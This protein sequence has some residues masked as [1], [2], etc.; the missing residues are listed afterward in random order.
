MRSHMHLEIVSSV[1]IEV[2]LFA[3]V[4][5]FLCMVSYCMNFQ[6]TSVSARILTHCAPVRL[7]PRVGP[8]VLLQ[9]A[10]NNC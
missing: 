6:I 8:Y 9:I 1:E 3:T 5:L 7:F 2:A 4:W 10:Q